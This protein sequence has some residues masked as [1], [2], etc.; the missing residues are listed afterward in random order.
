V[1]NFWKS[2]VD[3][4]RENL[5]GQPGH[6]SPIVA[7]A[8][9][10]LAVCFYELGTVVAQHFGITYDLDLATAVLVIPTRE[11]LGVDGDDRVCINAAR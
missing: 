4:S 7:V 1:A 6:W 10:P 3:M 11:T 5:L 2:E 8:D 9:L